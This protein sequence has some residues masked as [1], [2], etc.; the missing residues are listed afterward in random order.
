MTMAMDAQTNS[1]GRRKINGA[2]PLNKP[3]AIVAI[4]S[5][6]RSSANVDAI[7]DA[8]LNGQ[9][10]WARRKA[11]ARASWDDWLLVG[12]ALLVGKRKSVLAAKGNRGKKYAQ[13][14]C[15]WCQKNNFGDIDKADRSKLLWIMENIE[16]VEAWRATRSEKERLIWNHPSTVW[17]VVR[18]KR[19]G[20][21]E[22]RSPVEPTSEQHQ[23]KAPRRSERR[24]RDCESFQKYVCWHAEK[25]LSEVEAAARE[26]LRA[27]PPEPVELEAVAATV[28]AWIKLLDLMKSVALLHNTRQAA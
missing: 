5:G 18:C 25:S 6:V 9:Q 23:T 28:E 26:W 21:P 17:R 16:D 15:A 19:Q 12:W 10:A 24:A 8:I 20:L 14:F 27:S 1:K 13:H 22:F 4:A 11:D 2:A 3:K 7:E